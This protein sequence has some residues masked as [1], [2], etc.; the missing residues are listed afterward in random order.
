VGG[1]PRAAAKEVEDDEEA[2]EAN[3]DQQPN[4]CHCRDSDLFAATAEMRRG[5]GAA[6]DRG[7]R[8]QQ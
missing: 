2:I 3:G 7:D 6:T 5:F 8:R 4:S 1:A